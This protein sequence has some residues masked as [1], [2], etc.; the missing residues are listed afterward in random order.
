VF[1]FCWYNFKREI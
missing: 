1:T